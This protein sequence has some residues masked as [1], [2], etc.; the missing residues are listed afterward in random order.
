[1]NFTLEDLRKQEL[2]VAQVRREQANQQLI[3]CQTELADT[4]NTYRDSCQQKLD[5][6]LANSYHKFLLYRNKQV[7]IADRQLRQCDVEVVKTRQQLV[8]ASKEKK[9]VEKLKEKAFENY[10]AAELQR[11]IQFLDE[12]GTGQYVRRDGNGK[13]DS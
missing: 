11:E 2:Q 10:Q 9:V 5:L 12:L 6:Y 1:M 4:I 7:T 13:E 8:T 3:H